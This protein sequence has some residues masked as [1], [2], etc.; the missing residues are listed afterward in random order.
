[1]NAS[2]P[3]LD[4]SQ[5][6]V[7]AWARRKEAILATLK[8]FRMTLD[9]VRRH[10]EWIESR[11]H[12]SAVELWLIWELAQ[13]PGLRAV[14]LAKLMALPRPSTESL[15]EGLIKRGLVKDSNGEGSD[16]PGIF[17]TTFDGQR[18][19]DASPQYGQGVLKAAM[20]NLPDESLANLVQAM[21]DLVQN[22]PFLEERA[23][24]QPM[25]DLLRPSGHS[26]AP[27]ADA[28]QRLSSF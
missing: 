20:S 21:S 28:V 3:F 9:A 8:M 26:I 25:A 4:P 19:A 18:I 12:I 6:T 10:S 24:L 27:P 23:A 22:L 14:D 15:L 5:D 7:V 17:F 16:T 1:M 11:H 13:S 2:K